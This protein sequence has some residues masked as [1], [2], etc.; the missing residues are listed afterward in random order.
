MQPHK[1]TRLAAAPAVLAGAAAMAADK[2]AV[3]QDAVDQAFETLKT[4]DWG[5]DRDKLNA[6]DDAV[7]A[8][9]GDAAARKQ[10]ETRLAAVLKSD[11]SRSA[12]DYV[13]R[14]LRTIGTAESVPALAALLPDKELSHMSRYALERISAP[15]AAAAMR[16]A[17]PKLSGALKVGT[18]GSLGVRRDAD[19]VAALA[20]LLGDGDKAVASTAAA[21]LG[22]IGSPEAGQLLSQSAKKAPEGLKPAV[23]D[24]CL[25]CAEQLLADGKKAEAMGLYQAF[26]GEDQPRHIR[27]AVTRGLLKAAGKKD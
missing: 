2:P 20:G 12:K 7:I 19:A 6:I 22:M 24:A 10:L 3:D 4:Y 23:A 26:G 18:I 17:L 11:A 1:M 15:E 13:C 9:K 5:T 16:D 14:K 21:A 27:L 25:A 8:T